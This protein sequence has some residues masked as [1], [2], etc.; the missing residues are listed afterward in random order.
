MASM[1]LRIVFGVA[2]FIMLLL[3]G[4][5]AS[6]P[7]TPAPTAVTNSATSVSASGARL[8]GSADPNG[9]STNAWFQWG[10]S[11][12]YGNTTALNSVGSGT[13]P[14][15]YNA[16]LGALAC[17][18]TYHFRAVAQN[19]GGTTYGSNSSFTTSACTTQPPTAVTS[20]ASS[21]V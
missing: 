6:P 5:C 3:I 17:G 13:S 8:N 7:S 18:T 20:A 16:D 4:G 15:S 21:L 19:S 10:T 1:Y 9:A 11:T 14:I 2:V 12:A